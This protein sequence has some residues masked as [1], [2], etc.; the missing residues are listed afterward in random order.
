MRYMAVAAQCFCVFGGFYWPAP[1]FSTWKCA[2]KLRGRNSAHFLAKNWWKNWNASV[3]TQTNFFFLKP[4]GVSR[5]PEKRDIGPWGMRVCIYFPC[6]TNL[7]ASGPTHT[8]FCTCFTLKNCARS[9]SDRAAKFLTSTRVPQMC[10]ACEPR[11]ICRFH[12][13]RP[14]FPFSKD[15]LSGLLTLPCHR[16]ELWIMSS[17]TVLIVGRTLS[18]IWGKGQRVADQ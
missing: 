18:T 17:S 4:K 13:V 6:L 5:Q 2:S 8:N 9:T 15:N 14:P 7:V 16:S 11:D 12:T 10:L 3:P 1:A